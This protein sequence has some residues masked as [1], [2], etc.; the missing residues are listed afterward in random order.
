MLRPT[1]KT[2]RE[3]KRFPRGY[4]GH[5]ADDELDELRRKIKQDERYKSLRK[6]KVI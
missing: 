5:N 3:S 1:T 6:K 2:G 4:F